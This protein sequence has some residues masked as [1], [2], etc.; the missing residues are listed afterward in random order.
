MNPVVRALEST[1]LQLAGI[2]FGSPQ[3]TAP[4][5]VYS[6]A[7]CQLGFLNKLRLFE[8]FVSYTRPHQLLTHKLVIDRVV[9]SLPSA[10][11]RVFRSTARA[12][13]ARFRDASSQESTN[14][15]SHA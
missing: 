3:S 4:R 12:F 5:F 10:R 9:I 13:L 15:A 6:Q 1:S 7:S 8:T 11:A 2:L 14:A